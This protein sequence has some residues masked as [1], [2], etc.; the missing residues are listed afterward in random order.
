MT[1]F[2]PCLQQVILKEGNVLYDT[3]KDLP[4]P[5]YMQFYMFDVMNPDE[6]L[7][8]GKPYLRQVGPYTYR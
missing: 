5:I 2:P 8:G 7:A 6:V 3:W 1:S 4:I